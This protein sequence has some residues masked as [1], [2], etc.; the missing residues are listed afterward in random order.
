MTVTGKNR[1]TP[2]TTRPNATLS[3]TYVTITVLGSKQ[4]LRGE[5]PATKRPGHGL[6]F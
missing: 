6:G 4:E 3:T 1:S 5:E 2:R